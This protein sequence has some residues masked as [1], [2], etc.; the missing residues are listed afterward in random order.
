MIQIGEN[1]PT[2]FWESEFQLKKENIENDVDKEFSQLNK[3]E[4]QSAEDIVARL[5]QEIAVIGTEDYNWSYTDSTDIDIEEYS[6]D[7]D[8]IW[9]QIQFTELE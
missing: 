1:E 5:D 7:E 3:L 6:S 2:S 8:G 4:N 9:N